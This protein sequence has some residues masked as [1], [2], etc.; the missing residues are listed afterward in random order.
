VLSF[1][2]DASTYPASWPLSNL[3]VY[4][5]GAFVADCTGPGGASPDP[6]VESRTR[7]PDGD[8]EIVVR[9][10]SASDWVVGRA[11]PSGGPYTVAE[12]SS[13]TLAG[14]GTGGEA[15][16]GY[17]WRGAAGELDNETAARP[18]FTGA[19]DAALTLSLLVTAAAGLSGSDDATIT[20][21]NRP[22]TVS[23]IAVLKNERRRLEITAGFAD[24][25]R[26]DTHTA[27]VRWGDGGESAA[28]VAERGGIGAGFA[29]H[30]YTRAGT[31]TVRVTVRD[32]DGGER[33][34]E[35]RI[36]IR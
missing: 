22:P 30:D 25:G 24:A 32:D 28:R 26:L 13:V 14:S 16:L 8:A 3:L 1:R 10:S 33:S 23:P 15:P 7:H 18:R 19:D 36:Q 29:S 12:G 31:Y 34:V 11:G 27:L 20:V 2:V 17:R 9:S 35:R 21:T 5:D 4:R 6:C